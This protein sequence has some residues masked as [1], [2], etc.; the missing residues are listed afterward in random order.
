M[1]LT[2]AH[3]AAALPIDRATRAL[4]V[5]L[6]LSALMI[7]TWAPDFEYLL[8]LRPGGKFGHTPLGLIVFCLPLGLVAWA[9]FEWL[10]A[11]ALLPLLP[12]GLE[13]R[14][15]ATR[16]ARDG[17]QVIGA[18]AAVL[19]G[20]ISHVVW[21]AFGHSGPLGG[22]L[23]ILLR[24]AFPTV[25]PPVPWYKVVQHGSTVCGMVVLCAWAWWWLRRQ[26]P[27]TLAY[28]GRPRGRALRVVAGILGVA[29]VGAVL[30]A[31]RVQDPSLHSLLALAAVGAM[32]AFSLAIVSY[33]LL[34]RLGGGPASP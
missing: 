5:T 13:G 28:R 30:N 18:A 32:T 9:T 19:L 8:L 7:G 16:R 24:P 21:D 4:G 15:R 14:V 26:N 11:P 2:L 20:T 1:P 34:V 29:A 12:P 25:L 23:R 6:P 27:A 3:A 17:N 31:M 33:G 10:I 22:S